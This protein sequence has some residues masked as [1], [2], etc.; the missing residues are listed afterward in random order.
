MGQSPLTECPHE[1]RVLDVAAPE[2]QVEQRL[3]LVRAGADDHAG[4][5]AAGSRH[6]HLPPATAAYTRAQFRAH[7]QTTTACHQSCS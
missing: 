2:H 6:L 3:Q 5:A 7:H 4:V 1:Q